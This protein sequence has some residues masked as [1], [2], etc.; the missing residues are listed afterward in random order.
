MCFSSAEG[1][2]GGGTRTP[3]TPHTAF[4]H[5]KTHKNTEINGYTVFPENNPEIVCDDGSTFQ[6]KIQRMFD[7]RHARTQTQTERQQGATL[8][9]NQST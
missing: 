8:A 6:F 4:H 5:P 9:R 7:V 2:W 3:Q 1:V